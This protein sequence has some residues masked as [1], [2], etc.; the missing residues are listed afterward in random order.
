MDPTLAQLQTENATLRTEI[1]MRRRVIQR[2]PDGVVKLSDRLVHLN[3]APDEASKKML[4]IYHIMVNGHSC[5]LRH[6]SHRRYHNYLSRI[7]KKI[8]AEYKR[9]RGDDPAIFNGNRSNIYVEDDFTTFADEIIRVFCEMHPFE[10][11]EF[12]VDW[13]P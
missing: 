7:S 12:I 3:H 5:E 4:K 10:R 6:P 9:Q 1:G 2:A 13:T 11:Q 8:S